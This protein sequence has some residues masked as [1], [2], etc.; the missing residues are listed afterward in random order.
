M[1]RSYDA[2][3]FRE[4]VAPYPEIFRN[5]DFP[6]EEWL[7]SRNKM[8][9]EDGSVG[10]FS[11]EWPGVY[12]GHWF[13]KVRGKDANDLANR[14]LDKMFHEY[15]MKVCRGFTPIELPHVIKAAKRLGFKS[16]GIVKGGIGFEDKDYELLIMTKEEFEGKD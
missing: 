7:A 10:L 16:Y 6:F 4:A 13:F 2:D 9:V 3:I 15:D 14:I 1:E 12:T 5:E 11:Y 8:F